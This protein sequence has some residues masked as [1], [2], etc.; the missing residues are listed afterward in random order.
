[1]EIPP[2]S[3]GWKNHSLTN[4]P[5]RTLFRG[6]ET[7]K[8]VKAPAMKS[9]FLQKLG[10]RPWYLSVSNSK[11]SRGSRL[12]ATIIRLL[13]CCH[14]MGVLI[15]PHIPQWNHRLSFIAII[16]SRLRNKLPHSR[17]DQKWSQRG[18]SRSAFTPNI[19]DDFS[20]DSDTFDAIERARLNNEPFA[21]DGDY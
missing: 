2:L 4:R 14:H 5:Q 3:Q 11:L 18:R 1:M 13:W 17:S 12:I 10:V 21:N 8:A 16:V 19:G 9:W 7:V 15:R 20:I 6:A